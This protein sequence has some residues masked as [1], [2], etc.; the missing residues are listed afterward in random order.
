MPY[1]IDMNSVEWP[2]PYLQAKVD[3]DPYHRELTSTP[4]Y[5]TSRT[6]NR[7]VRNQ[8]VD[9]DVFEGLPVRHWRKRP[10]NVHTAPEKDAAKAP[11]IIENGYR[12]LPL[13]RD[14]NLLPEN[15]QALLR[16]ARM[17]LRSKPET[18]EDDKEI[19]ESEPVAGNEET[20]FLMH[21]W[22]LVPREHEGI[23]PE[24]LAKRRK[25]LPSVYSGGALNG[26][27]TYMRKT[28]V[29]KVDT[30]GT[31]SIWEVL[32]PEGHT[33]DNEVLEDEADANPAPAPGTIVEGVG[34][35]NAEGLVV[36]GEQTAPVSNRRKPPIPKKK[37]KHGPGR[38]RKKV[39]TP[40]PGESEGSNTNGLG[41]E[42]GH[43]KDR[44]DL[45]VLGEDGQAA[46]EED[47][48]MLD[49]NQ[50]DDEGT[51]EGS[52]I[53]DGDDDREDGELS[54]TPEEVPA[55]QIDPPK[56]ED[57]PR[58]KSAT[59]PPV[60]TQPHQDTELPQGSSIAE[61]GNIAFETQPDERPVTPSQP[62]QDLAQPG[63]IPG[64]YPEAH[65]RRDAHDL[66]QV[67][68]ETTVSTPHEPSTLSEAP[69]AVDEIDI[70]SP[71]NLGGG[72]VE[73]VSASAEVEENRTLPSL[74]L[75][76]DLPQASLQ[77]IV[78][79]EPQPSPMT[80][81]API[82][83]TA[84]TPSEISPLAAQLS[85]GVPDIKS[86][87]P[88]PLTLSKFPEPPSALPARPP[89]PPPPPPHQQQQ[90]LQQQPHPP[91]SATLEQYRRPS[92]STPQ[93]PT[94]SPPTPIETTFENPYQ[95]LSPK[96]P[97]MS[98]P[99]PIPADLD[100][101]PET[102]L[103][104]K[105]SKY[106]DPPPLSL[107]EAPRPPPPMAI[108]GLQPYVPEQRIE[109]QAAPPVNNPSFDAEIPHAHDPLDGLAAPEVPS[110]D[111][112]LDAYQSRTEI[113]VEAA[114]EIRSPKIDAEILHGHNPLDGLRP[115]EIPPDE[116]KLDQQQPGADGI[117]RFEDG[118]EDLLGT[119]ERSL[120]DKRT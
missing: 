60:S 74:A 70:S 98:P 102:A 44:T 11:S 72:E 89:S 12:E 26:D 76:V 88:I 83:Q 16:A 57:M 80:A 100:S 51:E 87:P 38:G 86:P 61:V 59:P 120:Q 117:V 25:G 84:S 27:T 9:H 6:S 53:E 20:G 55:I 110:D 95:G 17:G 24:Y 71:V 97:T 73:R 82:L 49:A 45:A 66:A 35:V 115:P 32:V 113:D 15:S 64:L 13:P 28:K 92:G 69:K 63:F 47:S 105:Q 65:T 67:D 22:T 112:K 78:S 81:V 10:V 119:H 62:A 8:A 99:T 90:Q 30:D 14:F 50:D 52:D 107:D 43:A 79:E 68:I 40:A 54:P 7:Q 34:I 1:I 5:R 93:A 37:K 31:T 91:P 56:Q 114:P 104:D 21:K 85:A 3:I 23:E 33:I 118:D 77:S 96:A 116:L 94:P 108:P 58:A 111:R 2:S 75:Q 41:R 36:A 19:E 106:S 39:S 101:S 109:V 42:N 103:A 29:K 46:N 4:Q 48:V 18:T